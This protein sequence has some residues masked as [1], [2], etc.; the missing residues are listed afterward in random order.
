MFASARCRPHC[1]FGDGLRFPA[2]ARGATRSTFAPP[3]VEQRPLKLRDSTHGAL[4]A[5]ILCP[6]IAIPAAI[7]EPGANG[8]VGTTPSRTPLPPRSDAGLVHSTCIP[9]AAV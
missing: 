1:A 4:V 3:A 7:V 5:G 9:F 6:R 2:P 8:V